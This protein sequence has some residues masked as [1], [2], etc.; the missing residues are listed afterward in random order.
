MHPWTVHGGTE[1]GPVKVKY[2]QVTV[3]L[4]G[5]DGNAFMV[6]GA[7]ARALRTKVG[8]TA[9]D[10]FNAAA[11]ACTDYDQVLALAQQTVNVE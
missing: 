10:A 7:V 1:L 2:P 3:Q 8:G 6:I 9:A 4:I 11:Y 5:T